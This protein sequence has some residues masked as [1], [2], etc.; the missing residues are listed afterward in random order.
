MIWL[1]STRTRPTRSA[2]WATI[3]GRWRSAIRR[4]RFW[5][6][7]SNQE[8]RRELAHKLAW[9]YERKANAVSDVGDVRGAVVLYDQA[10]AIRERLVNQEGRRE[11]VGDLARLKAYRGETLIALGEK[12]NGLQD[13]RAA[14]RI[15]DAEIARTSRTDLKQVLTWLQQQLR[16]HSA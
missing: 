11:L 2:L 16:E 4:L 9:V 1:L 10:I 14:Q 6:G 5:S 15:L 8:G 7:W 12:E 13:M 3:A